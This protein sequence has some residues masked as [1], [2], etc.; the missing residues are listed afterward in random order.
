VCIDC[1]ATTGGQHVHVHAKHRVGVLT[2]KFCTFVVPSANAASS[3]MRFDKLFE[4]GSFTV[5]SIRCTGAISN[6]STFS[7]RR[8][9]ARCRVPLQQRRTTAF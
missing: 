9:K 3:R 7:A 1:T 4:P 5:P 2:S 8:T 6:D